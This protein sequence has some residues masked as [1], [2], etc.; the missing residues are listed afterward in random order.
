MIQL[1][2]RISSVRLSNR[3]SIE[4]VLGLV[5]RK[6]LDDIGENGQRNDEE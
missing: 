1:V 3:V 2:D 6:L 5:I 4:K